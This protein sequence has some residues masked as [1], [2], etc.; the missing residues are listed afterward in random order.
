MSG[1]GFLGN[2]AENLQ[3]A[4]YVQSRQAGFVR[5]CLYYI[6]F[7]SEKKDVFMMH[8]KKL[9]A[10]LL[11]LVLTAC[12]SAKPAQTETVWAMDTACTISLHGGGVSETASLLKTLDKTL[13][14][15]QEDSAISQLN[16]SG[17]ISGNDTI[18][19]LVSETAALQ[20]R[21]GDSVD[22]TVGQLT[23]LWGITTD[24]PHVPTAAE[25]EPVLKTISLDHVTAADGTVTLTDGAQ[26][27]C[28]AVGKGYSLDCVK[29]ALDQSGTAGYGTVSMTSSILCYGEKPDGKPFQI[30]IRDPSGDGTLG[31]VS[32]DSCFLSTSGGYE[33]YFIADD[34]KQYCH[35]L[36]PKT[37]MPAES[38]LTTV[39]VFC[40]SGLQSDFLSTLIWLEGTEHLEE[41]LHAEDYQIVA[42]DQSGKLYVSDGLHFTP[43]A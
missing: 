26:L 3:Q 19:Q 6:T 23:A 32:T 42:Q 15:Y 4:D 13:D 12:T 25:L 31:T 10:V 28:G 39:T 33:R 29:E 22:L 11:P 2:M 38:D 40:D 1:K 43:N 37:G 5:C 27:D 24:T 9:F 30:E 35:I 16:Q 17:T 8:G 34:G 21:F 20:K 14:N 18:Y 41:H 7:P 36:D